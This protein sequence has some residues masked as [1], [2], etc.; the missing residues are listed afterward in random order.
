[1]A[2]PFNSVVLT[3]RLARDLVV[4]QNKDGSHTVLGTIAVDANFKN[5]AGETKTDFIPFRSYVGVRANGTGGW[6]NVGQGD[7]ISMSAHLDVTP[8][9]KDGETVYPLT[10]EV[11][12]FPQY[13]EARSTVAQ[14]RAEEAKAAPESAE[15]AKDRELAAL[16]AQVEQQGG[17]YSTENVY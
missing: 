13:L 16:R 1:M 5:R 2:N 9:E 7:L 11:D 10:V 8:Y 6:A 17:N 3:G 14:R 4:K 12:G 15:D